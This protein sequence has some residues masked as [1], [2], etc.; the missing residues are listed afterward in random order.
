MA[1]PLEKLYF[2]KIRPNSFCWRS[3]L[4]LSQ[5]VV[6]LGTIFT[7]AVSLS[8][9]LNVYLSLQPGLKLSAAVQF[10]SGSCYPIQSR[11]Q[12]TNIDQTIK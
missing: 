9:L 6:L 3:Q 8:W 12:D 10:F 7:L 11:V 2:P 4:N 1:Y 5:V